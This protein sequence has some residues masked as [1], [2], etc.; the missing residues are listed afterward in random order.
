MI[1]SLSQIKNRES[2]NLSKK[3]QKEIMFFLKKNLLRIIRFLFYFFILLWLI[4]TDYG[5]ILQ[6]RIIN[7]RGNIFYTLK[8]NKDNISDK[9]DLIIADFFYRYWDDVISE[10]EKILINDLIK[11]RYCIRHNISDC[12][13]NYKTLL[14]NNDKLSISSQ[15]QLIKSENE[16]LKEILFFNKNYFLIDFKKFNSLENNLK[17]NN[18]DADDN[19]ILANYIENNDNIKNKINNQNLHYSE[20]NN[21]RFS[22]V[23]T[24]LMTSSII[25]KSFNNT[26]S[27][28]IITAGSINGIMIGDLA[29]Y[30]GHFI[31]KVSAVS[32]KFS[33]VDTISSTNISVDVI[34]SSTG[35]KCIAKGIGAQD[36]EYFG[37]NA[38][39]C[40][41]KSNPEINNFIDGEI[42]IT[43]GIMPHIPAGL[44]VGSYNKGV[45]SPKF[46]LSAIQYINLIRYSK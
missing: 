3:F 13:L 29:I 4:F 37:M 42:I 20:V 32:E 1:L 35:L 12:K 23:F 25:G 17:Q 40:L 45:I 41:N 5:V 14:S 19:K 46:D 27:F 11:F 26:N 36:N 39:H 9:F 16:K 31:G 8:I 30:M 34:G 22:P 21:N 43:S 28:L 24:K 15:Y 38:Y 2:N 7:I 6:S 18:N 33:R 10:D 44:I